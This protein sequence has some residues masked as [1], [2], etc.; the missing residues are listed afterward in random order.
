MIAER[1]GQRRLGASGCLVVDC[2]RYNFPI[3]WHIILK[4]TAYQR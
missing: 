4:V 1:K 2:F 3:S